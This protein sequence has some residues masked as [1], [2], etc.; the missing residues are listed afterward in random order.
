MTQSKVATAAAVLFFL[1]LGPLA[2]F[3]DQQGRPGGRGRGMGSHSL[4]PPPGYL[5]LSEA[6]REAAKSI[7]EA[8]R[9][10]MEANREES[11]ALRQQL[12]AELDS[13][14]P[15]A[16][17][18]GRLTIDLHQLRQSAGAI[19]EQV[20]AEFGLILSAEQLEKWE[21]FKELRASRRS[22]RSGGPGKASLEK[23]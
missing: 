12:K 3:A 5:D 18:V 13:E 8:A 11:S 4:L 2:S 22:R 15:D 19:R 14:T 7:R 6:Q 21:N 20:E 9:S 1:L 23:R 10:E 17:N 16:M